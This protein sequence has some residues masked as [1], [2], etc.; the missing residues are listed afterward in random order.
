M[1]QANLLCPSPLGFLL[2]ALPFVP[3]SPFCLS[4]SPVLVKMRLPSSSIQH[5]TLFSDPLCRQPRPRWVAVWVPAVHLAW[6]QP[7][8]GEGELPGPQG[9]PGSTHWQLTILSPL[10]RRCWVNTFIICLTT[11]QYLLS[12]KPGCVHEPG[13]ASARSQTALRLPT[14]ALPCATHLAARVEGRG[15]TCSAA[16]I[17]AGPMAPT[18]PFPAGSSP[19]SHGGLSHCLAVL[20]AQ[21]TLASPYQALQRGSSG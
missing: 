7:V 20:V 4:R 10:R 12:A 15:S 9:Q 16:P 5:P 2:Q 18:A 1:F 3:V 13:G 8:P 21:C 14:G 19:V 17:L 11:D 6:R